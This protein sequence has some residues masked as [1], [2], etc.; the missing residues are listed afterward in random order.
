MNTTISITEA[1][2]KLFQIFNDVQTPGLSY[3]FTEKGRSKAVLISA[4]EFDSWKETLE[5]MKEFPDLKKNLEKVEKDIESGNYRQ[6]RTLEEVL[7]DY[8]YLLADKAKKKY[9]VATKT[10]KKSRKR[11]K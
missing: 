4:E 3:T 9:A 11:S 1:R 2:K 10:R 5:V 6:Y 8:G 7:S